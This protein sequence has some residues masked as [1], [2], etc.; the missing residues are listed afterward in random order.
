M[1]K[2]SAPEPTKLIA[3]FGTAGVSASW[4]S[5]RRGGE[6]SPYFAA[7]YG[8]ASGCGRG[9]DRSAAALLLQPRQS[10]FDTISGVAV[11]RAGVAVRPPAP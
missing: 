5:A 9:R 3:A 8:R 6:A 1:R 7:M 11:G 10:D 4:E 2:P